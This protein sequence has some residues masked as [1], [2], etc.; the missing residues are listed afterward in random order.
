MGKGTPMGGFSTQQ[1]MQQ[2]PSLPSNYDPTGQYGSGRR[3]QEQWRMNNPAMTMPQQQ[4]PQ[5]QLVNSNIDMQP[6]QMPIR[7]NPMYAPPPANFNVQQGTGQ[8]PMAQQPIGQWLSQLPPQ[9]S[10]QPN[11]RPM[12]GRRFNGGIM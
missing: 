4:M 7:E 2:Q 8:N 5:G 3:E 6:Q 11:M 10:N 1:K 9:V 12:R